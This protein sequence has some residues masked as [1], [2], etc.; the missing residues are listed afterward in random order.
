MV[1]AYCPVRGTSSR[2][3][4]PSER[5]L[6]THGQG[7]DII[8]S[9]FLF[10]AFLLIPCCSALVQSGAAGLPLFPCI[11]PAEAKHLFIKPCYISRDLLRASASRCWNSDRMVGRRLGY[12][13]WSGEVVIWRIC[14]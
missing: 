7:S 1:A 14:L 9:S 11:V 6:P 10:L 13:V 3:L 5:G 12:E 4:G 2:S 8:V